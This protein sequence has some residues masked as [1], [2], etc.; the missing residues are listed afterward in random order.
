MKIVNEL[1]GI[2]FLYDFQKS[3][4]QNLRK[5][6]QSFLCETLCL[7]LIYISIKHHKIYPEDCLQT[8][9]Q[10]HALIRRFF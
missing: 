10:R 7:D 9:G 8:D 1:W 3:K 2:H 4:T 6:V 5:G